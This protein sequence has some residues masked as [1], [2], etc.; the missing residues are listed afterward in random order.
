MSDIFNFKE[1]GGQL[2][3]RKPYAVDMHGAYHYF[4]LEHGQLR[5]LIASGRLHASKIGKKWIIKFDD[6][7]ALVDKNKLKIPKIKRREL[8]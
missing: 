7:A 3:D 8:K 1:N 5:A 2:D 4:G 6:L